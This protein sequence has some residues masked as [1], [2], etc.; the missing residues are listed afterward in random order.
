MLKFYCDKCETE[1]VGGRLVGNFS[2][3]SKDLLFNPKV[4]L[5]GSK[6]PPTRR[7]E[8]HLC[9]KCSEAILSFIKLKKSKI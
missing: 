1:I 3:I 9:E 5:E 4:N 8:F 7:E 6:V 2:I